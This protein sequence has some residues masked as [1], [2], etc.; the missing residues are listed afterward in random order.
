MKLKLSSTVIFLG[1]FFPLCIFGDGGTGSNLSVQNCQCTIG[2]VSKLEAFIIGCIG[3]LF[4]EVTRVKLEPNYPF[5][6]SD[7]YLKNIV[8]DFHTKVL[9]GLL[10]LYVLPISSEFFKNMPVNKVQ[11][12]T[13]ITKNSFLVIT[14][15]LL[16]Y[17]GILESLEDMQHL[18]KESIAI[19]LLIGYLRCLV[20]LAMKSIVDIQ[21]KKYGR[22][23]GFSEKL[24]QIIVTRLFVDK[25]FTELLKLATTCK[26]SGN[27]FVK[28]SVITNNQILQKLSDNAKNASDIGH[29]FYDLVMSFIKAR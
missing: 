11:F 25:F 12:I 1:A 16:F 27:K 9:S 13:D 4:G 15:I 14:K 6:E 22:F 19:S 21:E 28:R 23:V 17:K 8:T 29:T 2:N 10:P 7:R 5:N 3:A 24:A 26:S 18:A 20:G